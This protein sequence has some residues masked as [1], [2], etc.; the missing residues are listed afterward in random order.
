M[1][2]RSS[3]DF[4]IKC[5]IQDRT[6]LKNN[7]IYNLED[8]KNFKGNIP[9]VDLDVILQNNIPSH[10]I[11]INSHNWYGR[12]CHVYHHN[13]LIRAKIQ[14]IIIDKH[15]IGI[16]TILSNKKIITI[17]PVT[18]MSLYIHWIN[19]DVVSDD[20]NEEFDEVCLP[21]LKI[22][23]TSRSMDLLTQDHKVAL[24]QMLKETNKLYNIFLN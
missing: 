19:Y 1:F 15:S 22:D 10:K 24:H 8:L 4:I 6:M 5:S 9:G 13:K 7:Q 21:K 23:I 16:D 2:T 3:N 12:T 14:S 20:D 18:L 11:K 17:S